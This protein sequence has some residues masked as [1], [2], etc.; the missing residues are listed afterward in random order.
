MAAFRIAFT[1][2]WSSVGRLAAVAAEVTRA[3]RTLLATQRAR[4]R[5]GTAELAAIRDQ[6]KANEPE[7]VKAMAAMGRARTKL[8]NVKT[9]LVAAAALL[10]T[11]GRIVDVV[12]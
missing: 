1:S 4:L 7:L 8:H 12:M 5:L 6:L 3:A 2:S 10:R 11:V 9:V